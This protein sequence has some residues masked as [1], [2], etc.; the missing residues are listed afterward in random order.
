MNSGERWLNM[1]RFVCMIVLTIATIALPIVVCGRETS[2]EVVVQTELPPEVSVHIEVE[3]EASEVEVSVPTEPEKVYYDCPL[4]HELQDYIEGL[5]DEYGLPMDMVIA[6]ISVES[7]FQA[8]VI[9]GTNDYGLMQ[10]NKINHEWLST[11]YGITD[12]LDPYQNVLCGISILAQHYSKYQD[13]DK[14][15]MAYNLGATGA[16]RLWNE[17]VFE[18]FYTQKV[19]EAMEVYT[20]EI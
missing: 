7:C 5:C 19:K 18:T 6:L 20:N 13:V 10:I 3:S 1:I 14:T 2:Q 17:G 12:F 4:D 15:L 11:K 9:S 8:N 16:N